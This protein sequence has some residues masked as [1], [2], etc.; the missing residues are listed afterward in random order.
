MITVWEKTQD[1]G[2]GQQWKPREFDD[3][4]EAIKYLLN[5]A[6]TPEF[7]VT[8]DMTVELRPDR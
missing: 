3:E 7:R 4:S 6:T 1:H 5:R 2:E 8:Q